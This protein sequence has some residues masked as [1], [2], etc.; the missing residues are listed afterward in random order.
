[1]T[2][3]PVHTFASVWDALEAT[4]EDIANMRL[5]SGLAIALRSTVEGWGTTPAQSARRLG[6]TQPRLRNLLRGRTDRSSL[7]A[8]IEIADHARRLDIEAE[9]R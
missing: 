1:M 3:E 7:S 6:V 9:T 4:P 5:R 8:L 2:D